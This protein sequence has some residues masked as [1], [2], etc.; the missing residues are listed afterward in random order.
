MAFWHP[1]LSWLHRMQG[2]GGGGDLNYCMPIYWDRNAIWWESSWMRYCRGSWESKLPNEWRDPGQEKWQVWGQREVGEGKQKR[3]NRRSHSCKWLGRVCSWPVWHQDQALWRFSCQKSKG[4]M[5]MSG[6]TTTNNIS[7]YTWARALSHAV[8]VTA[9]GA[10]LSY[11]SLRDEVQW[12][13]MRGQ[14]ALGKNPP[15]LTSQSHGHFICH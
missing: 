12:G 11:L 1:P 4:F 3:R 13:T 10:C 8:P 15:N 6:S 7:A 14:A 9:G 2:W 5:I